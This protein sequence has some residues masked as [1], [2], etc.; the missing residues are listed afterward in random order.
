MVRRID[1]GG[2]SVLLRMPT[3]PDHL[4]PLGEAGAVGHAV[5]ALRAVVHQM[6]HR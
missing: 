6:V 4:A 5:G 3:V 2:R 1:R